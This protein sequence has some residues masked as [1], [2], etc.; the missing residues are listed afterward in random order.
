MKQTITLIFD[1]DGTLADTVRLAHGIFNRLSPH[2]GYKPIDYSEIEALRTKT[3][4]EFLRHAG[5]PFWKV[6]SLAMR[7]R[8]EMLHDITSV[9]PPEGLSDT[10]RKLH[11]C[12]RYSLGIITSNARDNVIKFLKHHNLDSL[13]DHIQTTTSVLSKKRRVKSFVKKLDLDRSKVFYVGD[14]T[15]D[16]D[17]A[18]KAGVNIISVS[19]GFNSE[20][21]LKAAKPDYLITRPEQLLDIFPA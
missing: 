11:A 17:S 4:H 15:V 1:F 19:W 3:L 14:T 10:L 9:E 2:F 18:H 21:R 8:H 16:I 5:I 6:P 7:A 13:F 20:S 12:G